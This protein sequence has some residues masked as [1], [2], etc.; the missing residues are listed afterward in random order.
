MWMLLLACK[1]SGDSG[2]YPP[3]PNV[4]L[5]I[6]D[7]FGLDVASFDPGSPCYAVGEVGNDP[8]MPHVA[9]LCAEGVRFDAAWAMPTCSPFRA[10]AMT[11]M[12]PDDHGVG[13]ALLESGSLDPTSHTLARALDDQVR[14]GLIGKW[15][16]SRDPHD[17]LRAGWDH[18]A[19]L[20]AGSLTDYRDWERV[21]GGLAARVTD[22]A[23][24]R[25]VDDA[26]AWLDQG[27]DPWLL[28]LAFTAPHTPFHVPPPELFTSPDPGP[29]TGDQP[30]HAHV[31]VMAEA[32]DAELG[33]LL[34]HLDDRGELDDTYVIF[35]G[36][37]GSHR[38]AVD[39]PPYANEQAKGT[40]YQGGLAVPL[41]VWGPG[42]EPGSTDALVMAAD[43]Y[44][45]IL[46][47][48]G[49]DV[50]AVDGVSL[51]PCLHGDCAP[52][53]HIAASSFGYD[54]HFA[55]EGWAVRDRDHKLICGEDGERLLFELALGE[56]QDVSLERPDVVQSLA[57]ALHDLTGDDTLCP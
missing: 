6:A 57:A 39:A 31:A 35:V 40:L 50:P 47:L 1:S 21:E 25:H 36:D 43:L 8:V 12:L 27:D 32:L 53:D 54:E 9:R 52:H 18:Y 45:T 29:F 23:T 3:G 24:T 51:V 2:A 34:Q 11:G 7:D 5:V 16:V 4:L 15:H 46:E 14:T 56:S 33:R 37:N 42:I 49:A 13:S 30:P 26:I 55:L 10:T 19:G 22:Y 20:I 28:W 38:D 44:P 17:P 41:L 48:L